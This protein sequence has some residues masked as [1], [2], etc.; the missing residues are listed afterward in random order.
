VVAGYKDKV[1]SRARA[2]GDANRVPVPD[3]AAATRDYRPE[4][5]G[6]MTLAS[7][8]EAQGNIRKMTDIDDKKPSLS[9]ATL[10]GLTAIHEATMAHQ[11]YAAPQAKKDEP[12]ADPPPAPVQPAVPATESKDDKKVARRPE[13]MSDLEFELAMSR[14]RSDVINNEKEREAVKARV[15]PMDLAEGLLSGEFTQDVPIVPEKLTVKFRS[16]APIENE[17]IKRHCLE[18]ALKDERFAEIA[19]DRMG[20]MQVVATISRVNGKDM[21]RHLKSE[22]F[23]RKFDW[24]VFL[25]KV[26]VFSGYPAPLLASLTAHSVWFDQR[27]RELFA[28]TNLKNG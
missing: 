18:E 4:K 3:I 13:D 27:V 9:K 23:T 16:L 7:I 28:T 6:P 20:F 15:Q 14:L 10:E 12:V 1:A 11:Q 8:G 2:Q 25:K 24:D 21:P 26:A 17:E 5:D 19:S 22:G